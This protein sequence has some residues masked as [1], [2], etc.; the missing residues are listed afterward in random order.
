MTDGLFTANDNDRRTMHSEQQNSQQNKKQSTKTESLHSKQQR[1]TA[2]TANNKDRQ[3]FT[4]NNKDRQ[5]SQETTNTY[6]LHSKQQRQTAFTANNKDRQGRRRTVK[7][8]SHR[9]SE[10]QHQHINGL[11]RRQDQSTGTDL[12]CQAA[13]AISISFRFR[14]TGRESGIF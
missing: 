9:R 3:A 4:A 8:G 7:R 10:Q 1:Q 13:G 11:T 6:S 2:F 14:A 12:H 5:P